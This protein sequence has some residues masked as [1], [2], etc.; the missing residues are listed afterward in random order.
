[1]LEQ[2]LNAEFVL[3]CDRTCDS[4]SENARTTFIQVNKNISSVNISLA[5]P[6]F[7][8]FISFMQKKRE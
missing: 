3:I 2:S 8:I 5:T 1:M 4:C 6:P 7:Q